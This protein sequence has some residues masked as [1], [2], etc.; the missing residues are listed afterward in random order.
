MTRMLYEMRE[1]TDGVVA[2]W[3]LLERAREKVMGFRLTGC[4]CWLQD[5]RERDRQGKGREGKGEDWPVHCYR[6]TSLKVASWDGH[7]STLF[8]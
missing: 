7:V 1:V 6:W 3:E 5:G 2:A 8:S 4:C